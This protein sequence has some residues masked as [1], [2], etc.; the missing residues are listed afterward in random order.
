M[1]AGRV[2]YIEL[3]NCHKLVEINLESLLRIPGSLIMGSCNNLSS[4]LRESAFLYLL[5]VLS[6]SLSL[7]LSFYDTNTFLK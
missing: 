3:G 1:K 4:D 5:K 2:A 7:S 6:L